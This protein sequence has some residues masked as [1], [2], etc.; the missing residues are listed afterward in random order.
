MRFKEFL[1]AE[2]EAARYKKSIPARDVEKMLN[3][4]CKDAMK[5]FHRPIWRG[6]TSGSDAMIIHGEA[7]G[8]TSANTSNYYTVI[9]DKFLPYFGYPKRSK[10]IICANN[11]NKDYTRGFGAR[12]AIFPYDD[13]SIGVCQSYDLWETP[14]FKIGKCPDKRSIE[15]WNSFYRRNGLSPDSWEEFKDSLEEK[16]QGDSEESHNLLEWFGPIEKISSVFEQ[17]YSPEN[18]GLELTN[19][20]N[21]DKIRGSH[22]LWI[23]GPCIAISQDVW[24]EMMI[25]MGLAQK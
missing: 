25:E 24:D 7:G 10:S 9:M 12:Y 11:E 20:A 22:E 15:S 19:S 21:I 8:R 23:G 1:L 5:L 16:M 18:L 17:A 2:E 6:M 4:H 3:E 13:V 14:S